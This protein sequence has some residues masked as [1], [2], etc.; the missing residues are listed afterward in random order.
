LLIKY[1]KTVLW[2]AAKRLSFIEDA[3]C[4]KVKH[5]HCNTTRRVAET[6]NH[7]CL[8]VSITLWVQR[9]H[10]VNLSRLYHFTYGSLLKEH[11]AENDIKKRGYY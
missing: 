7:V 1:I 5:Y 4:L 10:T 3:W 9:T 11:P 6:V 2:R 8:S